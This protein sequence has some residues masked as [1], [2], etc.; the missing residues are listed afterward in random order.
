[1]SI[2]VVD[3]TKT[4]EDLG[5]TDELTVACVPEH[6]SQPIFEL[7]D[8]TDAFCQHGLKVSVFS[9]PGGTGQMIEL[10]NNHRCD[11]VV[12]LTEGVVFKAVNGVLNGNQDP[13]TLLGTYVTS[14]LCWSVAVSPESHF[15]SMA[16]LKSA[17]IGISRFGS[18]SHIM[19]FV[20][21]MQNGWRESGM[22]FVEVLDIHGL[23]NGIQSGKIDCFLWETIT[24]KPYYDAGILKMLGTVT[25][26]WPAFCLATSKNFKSRTAIK[27]HSALKESIQSFIGTFSDI[28]M[29]KVMKNEKLHYPT[30]GDIET[31]FKNVEFSTETSII[32]RRD[33]ENCVTAL[34]KSKLLD[35]EQIHAFEMENGSICEKICHDV[36]TII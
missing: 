12:G 5:V 24:T 11:I 6:F 22:T 7:A 32:Q 31:W 25:A 19:S 17:K 4:S 8:H 16:D 35:G 15:E 36:S 3:L 28:G 21:Q 34:V 20:M 29:N 1:M 27:F 14:P 18:G 23:I 2:T 33:I 13:V 9:S 10:L 30:A 26:S